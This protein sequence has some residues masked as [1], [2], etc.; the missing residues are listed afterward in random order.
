M[1]AKT[2]A[3]AL[4]GWIGAAGLA[5]GFAL[6]P[7]DRS[8]QQKSVSSP[9]I[10][11][12]ARTS[13]VYAVWYDVPRESLARRRA[14]KA[15]LT[16]A[17]NRLPIGTL[18]RV[19]NMKNDKSVVVRITDRGI[20]NKRAKI[21]ICKEAAIEIGMLRDGIA[22]VRIEVLATPPPASVSGSAKAAAHSVAP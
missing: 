1:K 4:A 15:E 14:G 9:R 5:F 21:D 3:V 18:V 8:N 6:H 20:T 13:E 11:S 10:K 17:H 2:C 7:S 19:T 16:A 12:S 22:H